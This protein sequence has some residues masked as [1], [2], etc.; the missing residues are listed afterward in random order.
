[1]ERKAKVCGLCLLLT[2]SERSS[3]LGEEGEMPSSTTSAK[4]HSTRN[5]LTGHT[6]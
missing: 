1:M 3:A 4:E 5:R 6:S 2:F